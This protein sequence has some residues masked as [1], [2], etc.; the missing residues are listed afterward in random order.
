[1]N[2]NSI[3]LRAQEGVFRFIL[4]SKNA[5]QTVTKSALIKV[6]ERLVYYSAVGDPSY[7]KHPPHKGYIPGH[8]INNWQLGVDTIPSGVIAG[9]DAS[10]Q[11]SLERMR[12]AIPRWPV[13]HVY[14]FVNNVPY[15]RV[16][17]MGGHSPQVP[18]GGMVGRTVLEFPQIAREAEVDYS[19][20][21]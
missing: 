6:G 4:K 21:L 19:K 2:A 9:V 17:E 1:M 14:H 10:G 5:V 7:W 18:P 13:G 11:M 8:F 16:L 15:A 3:N 20:G 12:K